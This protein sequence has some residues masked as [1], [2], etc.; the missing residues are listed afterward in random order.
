MSETAE[1][2][3]KSKQMAGH[4]GTEKY[5]AYVLSWH[6]FLKKAEKIL[7]QF[8]NPEEAKN[9]SMYIL[10]NFFLAPWDF[11]E[12]FYGQFEEKLKVGEKYFF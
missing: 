2:Q 6:N 7:G 8:Q 10:K 12:D 4:S 9:V 1:D 11:T 3:S 5:E